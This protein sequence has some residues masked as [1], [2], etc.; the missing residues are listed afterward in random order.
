MYIKSDTQ[1]Y[2][3][4]NWLFH[5]DPVYPP[6]ISTIA[7]LQGIT[8][9]WVTLTGTNFKTNDQVFFLQPDGTPLVTTIRYTDPTHLQAKVPALASPLQLVTQLYDLGTFDVGAY[10]SNQ[11]IFTYLPTPTVVGFDPPSDA[12]GK[13][14]LISGSGFRGPITVHFT[15]NTGATDYTATPAS[16]QDWNPGGIL[17]TIPDIPLI[18]MPFAA[19]KIVV[20]CNGVRSAPATFNVTPKMDTQY[21]DTYVLTNFSKNEDGD[22]YG[23]AGAVTAPTLEVSHNGGWWPWSIHTGTDI[24]NLPALKNGWVL[25]GID[26]FWEDRIDHCDAS[27]TPVGLHTLLGGATVSWRVLPIDGLYYDIS[28]RIKGPKGIPYK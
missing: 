10:S 27:M 9:D 21:A 16:N 7:P 20:E 11:V 2:T 19:G 18:T 5:F 17:V 25:D 26:F 24:I 28:F 1:G 6:K 23:K 8:G 14:L 15:L 12:P 22:G 3:T 4:N 13:P